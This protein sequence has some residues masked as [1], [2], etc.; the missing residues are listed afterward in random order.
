VQLKEFSNDVCVLAL[1]NYMLSYGV[2]EKFGIKLQKPFIL[3]GVTFLLTQHGEMILHINSVKTILKP[4][5]IL[6]L[7]PHCLIEVHDISTDY[8][9]SMQFFSMDYMMDF[10]FTP[11]IEIPLTMESQPLLEVSGQELNYIVKHHYFILDKLGRNHSYRDKIISK[12]L[13]TFILEVGGLYTREL[14]R[15]A[16]KTSTH[17]Q[18]IVGRFFHLLAAHSETKKSIAFYA[19]KL[20]LTPKYVSQLITTYTGRSAQTWINHYVCLHAKYLLRSTT[21]TIAQISEKLGFPNPSFFSRF[22][23]QQLGITPGKY[24]EYNSGK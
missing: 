9:G 3:E 21:L 7:F 4:N 6:T 8:R 16:E 11:D 23:K 18:N 10:F 5:S 12:L 2:P 17:N 13:H 24:R 22:I 15:K 14:T 1:K 19:D 20:Y